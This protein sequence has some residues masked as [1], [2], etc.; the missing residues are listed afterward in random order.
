M[1]TA[2]LTIA[3]AALTTLGAC[4]QT[5]TTTASVNDAKVLTGQDWTDVAQQMVTSITRRDLPAT[6]ASNGQPVVI[7]VGDFKNQTTRPQFTRQKDFMYNALQTALVNSGQFTVNM[8]IA[9]AGGDIEDLIRDARTLRFDPEYN[10]QTTTREGTLRAPSLILYG[11]INSIRAE[12]GRT[13]QYDYQVN[14]RL[15]DVETGE[16]IWFGT[17]PLTK[18]FTRS[19]LGS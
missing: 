18:T 13:T 3:L 9:G 10:E 16:A 6:Y 12:Q 1:K 2:A 8:D 15:I 4:S 5:Q 7:A 19:F 17:V 11:E 14:T